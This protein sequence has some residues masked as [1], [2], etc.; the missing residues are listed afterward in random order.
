MK[1]LRHQR[2]SRSVSLF[3]FRKEP[4]VRHERALGRGLIGKAF[5]FTQDFGHALGDIVLS[6]PGTIDVDAR[7][8]SGAEACGRALPLIDGIILRYRVADG[9]ALRCALTGCIRN[10][11]RIGHGLRVRLHGRVGL[12]GGVRLALHGGLHGSV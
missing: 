11:L 2:R 8:K 6:L 12:H 3:V 4:G 5:Q 7:K 1:G 10:T 9:M